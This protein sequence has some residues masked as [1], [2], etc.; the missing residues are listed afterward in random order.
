MADATY[1]DATYHKQGGGEYVIASGGALTVES[2]GSIDI[3]TG[4]DLDLQS[5]GSITIASGASL[6]I[7]S[8]GDV[9]VQS[10]ATITAASGS[11]V[12]LESGSDVDV[13]SGATITVAAVGGLVLAAGEIA[14]A[15]IAA[16]AITEAKLQ[17]PT[18]DALGAFRIARATYDFGVLGGVV[19][20]IGL[21]VTVPDNAIIVGGFYDVL[22]TFTSPTTD[23]ATVAISVEGANDIVAAV[24]IDT[25]TP[26]DAGLRAIIPK[27]TTPESTGVKTSSAQEI[28]L[29]VGV[30]NLTA[31]KLVI[32]LYYVVSD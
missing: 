31:G 29:T 14:T 3:E 25:G 26:W 9:D 28:T 8:G 11:S 2:G 4:G 19:G 15:D 21:G 12:D 32:W 5:G 22:T 23:D 27:A 1:T 18:D 13:Q 24:A 30:E 17:L 16:A 6:D 20:A 10:G 7:E